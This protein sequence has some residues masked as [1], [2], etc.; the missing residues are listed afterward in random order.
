M[1]KDIKL[2]IND[3]KDNCIKEYIPIIKFIIHIIVLDI[4]GFKKLSN[5]LIN[6]LI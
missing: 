1:L 3:L 6:K 2:P 4:L 5:I